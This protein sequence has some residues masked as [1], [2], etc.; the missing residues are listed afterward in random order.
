MTEP[1]NSPDQ[2]Q[3]V[4]GTV[5]TYPLTVWEKSLGEEYEFGS[6]VTVYLYLLLA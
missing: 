6:T 3:T 2:S 5:G 4:P 1:Y